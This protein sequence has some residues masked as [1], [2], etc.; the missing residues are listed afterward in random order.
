MWAMLSFTVEWGTS[1]VGSNARLA[2]RIR[3]NMSE[4]GSVIKF[5]PTGFGHTGNQPVERRMTKRQTRG[6][7][8]AQVTAT[9]SA[10]SAAI[11]QPRW[12][13]VARQLGEAHVI[14]FRF[15]FSADCGVFLHRR[16]EE[17]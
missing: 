1:T 14:A 13:G 9:A 8:L 7:E 10:V 2:L 17:H 15:Q 11:H 6:V 12:A 5:L 4:I 16:S 3:V